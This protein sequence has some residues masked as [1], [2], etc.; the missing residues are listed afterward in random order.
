MKLTVA[1]T[2][3]DIERH[4]RKCKICNHEKKDE[5][6]EDYLN[7]KPVKDIFAEYIIPERS[8]YRH[9]QALGLD[10]KKHENRSKYYLKIM[11]RAPLDNVKLS[12]AIAAARLL[13]QVEGKIPG[14]NQGGLSPEERREHYRDI[15]RIVRKGQGKTDEEIDQEVGGSLNKE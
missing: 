6:E 2:N 12:V 11:E 8:F 13:E 1:A 3:A 9:V 5:I 7:W 10:K 14:D 15:L 4:S